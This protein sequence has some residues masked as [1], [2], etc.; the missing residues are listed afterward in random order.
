[1]V[2]ESLADTDKMD[3]N[4]KN[5]RYVTQSFE[6]FME[7]AS[8]GQRVYMRALSEEKPSDAPADFSEDFPSL[9]DDFQVPEQLSYVKEQLFSSVLRISGRVNMW[10]HYDVSPIF[11]FVWW[12]V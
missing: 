9:A 8:S 7:K 6:T 5:F 4:S 1:M 2:H 10:L 11:I 3:F 12:N